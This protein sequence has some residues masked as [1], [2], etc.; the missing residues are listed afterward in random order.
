MKE[1][2]EIVI[3]YEPT[4]PYDRNVVADIVQLS[5]KAPFKLVISRRP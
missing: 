1:A 5:K 4:N 3:Q 2:S